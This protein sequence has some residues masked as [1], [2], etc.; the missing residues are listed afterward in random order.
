MRIASPD[1]LQRYQR[2]R[3][4]A[5]PGFW[6]ALY[7]LQASVNSWLAWT[8]L[9]RT[10]VDTPFWAVAVWE[11][12]SNLVLLALVPVVILA[13]QYRPLHLVF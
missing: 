10:G 2:W 4:V 8:D 1:L 12:S 5:E 6:I 9:Q 7:L 11:W 3:R 13:G